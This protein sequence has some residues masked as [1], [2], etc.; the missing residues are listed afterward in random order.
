MASKKQKQKADEL[1]GIYLLKIVMFFLLGCLWVNIGTNPGLPVPIGLFIGIVF[2]TH[3]HFKIDRK[4][5]YVVL[6][7]ATVL[8][9]I[10]PIGFVLNI[11]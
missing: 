5:E 7:M 1:D 3:D 2:A 9:F 8:S 10:A 6:L 11:G 4:I